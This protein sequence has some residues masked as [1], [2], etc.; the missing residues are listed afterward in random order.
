ML[1]RL[2]RY[3]DKISNI[4]ELDGKKSTFKTDIT[5]VDYNGNDIIK[6][7]RHKTNMTVLGGRLDILEKPF[8]ITPNPEQRISL[9]TLIPDPMTQDPIEYL[10]INH[11]VNV[12]DSTE[13]VLNPN[14]LNRYCNYWC[15]GQGGEDK[16]V[17]YQIH[18]VKPWENRL[19]EMVPFRCV[20]AA[21]DLLPTEQAQ[22]RLRKVVEIDNTDYVCYYAKKFEIGTVFSMKD[23]AQYSSTNIK[24]EDSNPY[25]LDGDGHSMRGH[26][27]N[28]YV[29]FTLDLTDIEFKEFYRKLHNDSLHGARLSELGLITGFDANNATDSNRKELANAELFAKMTHDP[30]FLSTP[31]S[32]RKVYYRI[33][34]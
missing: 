30:V 27:V 19:Y 17:P 28:V 4:H 9:N 7:Q 25:G 31:G 12:F 34:S 5:L 18:D 13:T 29:E 21:N 11:S 14:R 24:V 33:Y 3:H 2:E 6:I 23:D 32:R 15:I 26:T 8:G 20:S 22:Y 1:P 16:I 10:T